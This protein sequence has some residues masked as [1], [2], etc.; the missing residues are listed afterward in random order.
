[1]K[2]ELKDFYNLVNRTGSIFNGHIAVMPNKFFVPKELFSVSVYGDNHSFVGLNSFSMLT[3][4]AINF[5]KDLAVRAA[6]GE[7][8]ERYCAQI[9]KKP[10]YYGSFNEFK[11][12]FNIIEPSL[13]NFIKDEYYHTDE[14]YLKKPSK[15]TDMFWVDAK[16]YIS[17]EKKLIPEQVA[18]FGNHSNDRYFTSTSTGMAAG[19]TFEN[20]VKSGLLE[21]LERHAFSQFWYFQS[22]IKL[23][24]HNSEAILEKFGDDNQ[25][26]ILY[27]NNRIKTTVYDLTEFTYVPTYLVFY[28]YKYKGKNEF[29]VGCASRFSQKDA[30]LKAGLEAYQGIGYGSM[31]LEKFKDIKK[32]LSKMNLKSV[33]S[34]FNRHYWYYHAYPNERKGVVIFDELKLTSGFSKLKDYSKNPIKDV[35]S[36]IKNTNLNNFFVV[37]LTFNPIKELEYYVVKV[38]IPELCLLTGSYAIPL[39]NYKIFKGKD[40]YLDKPHFFP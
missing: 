10:L 18:S 26:Q 38:V 31:L 22:N 7:V 40:I 28:E 6:F 9:P 19:S 8:L 2:L 5:N 39:L 30:L 25:I 33:L 11:N 24:K 36:F 27:K 20:A 13:F 15:D 23:K 12:K 37:D 35:D 1:M 16:D 32:P 21:C 4:S 29:S 17:N 34:D 3:G 14:I